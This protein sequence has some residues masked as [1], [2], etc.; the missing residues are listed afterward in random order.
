MLCINAEKKRLLSLF[1]FYFYLM[2]RILLLVISI[3]LSVLTF[4]QT[5]NDR[6]YIVK[7]GDPM[8]ELHMTLTDGTKL[9]PKD[10]EGK[11]VLLQFTASWCGVCRKEMPHLERDVWQKYKDHP[12][13]I[14]VGIDLDEP[15]EKVISFGES[16][17]VTYP[18]A[19]DPGGEIF[20]QFAAPK[21]GVTRNILCDRDGKIICLTRLFDPEEFGQM[22]QQIGKQLN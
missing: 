2:H 8:P 13:F 20:Y 12:D 21:A 17:D 9:S 1:G 14:M 10:L 11:V 19:L 3:A 16:V 7:V 4:S 6:G 22:K 18:L 15:L 5:K